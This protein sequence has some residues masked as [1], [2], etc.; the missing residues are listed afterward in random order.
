M[1]I[2]ENDI[3]YEKKRWSMVSKKDVAREAGVSATSVSY[4]INKSG[5]VS[6]EAGKKIQAAIERLHYTP[7]QIARSLKIKDS[8]Q[9][10]FLCN[11]I[12]NP[13]FAQLVYQATRE[14]YRQD[15]SILFSNVIDDEQYL[16]KI[17]GYQVSGVFVSNNRISCEAIESVRQF[18][19]PIVMLQDS[20]WESFHPDITL[21]HIEQKDIFGEITRHLYENGFKRLHYISGAVSSGSPD[22]KTKAFLAAANLD[23]ERNVSY[24]ITTSEQAAV[25]IRTSWRKIGYPDAIICTNDAV[26]EGVIF[27]LNELGIRVPKDVGVVG[28]DNTF[29]SRFYI[30]SISTVDFG[31]DM[32]GKMIIKMLIDKMQG[33]QVGNKSITPVFLARASSTR[34][35]GKAQYK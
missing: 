28:Y 17:C 6:A 23:G 29:Q 31:G 11:E 34:N 21:I 19:I 4:Y 7:S 1:Y 27:G 8:K 3:E 30:P 18:G 35:G 20:D 25:Y 13:F 5:Y 12:R 32:L 24:D 33:K 16:K 22:E 2:K 26:A 9:F 14:A 15:Y 10:V